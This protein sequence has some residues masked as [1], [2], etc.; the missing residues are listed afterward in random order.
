MLIT[1]KLFFFSLG[2]LHFGRPF[3]VTACTHSN[4]SLKS[5]GLQ[6]PLPPTCLHPW[7]TVVA[8]FPLL[9]SHINCL[10]DFTEVRKLYVTVSCKNW[11]LLYPIA[12]FKADLPFRLYALHQV[13]MHPSNTKFSEPRPLWKFS[14]P[15]PLQKFNDPVLRTQWYAQPTWQ[16]KLIFVSREPIKNHNINSWT[17]MRY[18][19]VNISLIYHN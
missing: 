17:E 8:K 18:Q 3:A 13:F 10:G 16:N 14:E 5:G 15:R 7:V 12:T 4:L 19:D 9:V 6:P 2:F 1:W 11:Q